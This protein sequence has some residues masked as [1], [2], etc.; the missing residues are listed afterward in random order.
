[1]AEITLT[2]ATLTRPWTAAVKDGSIPAGTLGRFGLQF[3]EVPVIIQAF[4]RMV[5]SLDFDVTEMAFTTYLCA[6]SFGKPFTALPVFLTRGFHHCAITRSAAAGPAAADAVPQALEGQRAGVSRGYTVTTGVWA[7]G[8]LA[9]QYGVDLDRVTWVPS[10]DD[11]VTEYQPP[12]NVIPAGPG[13]D[14]PA[15]V[16]SGEL[17][18]GVGFPSGP[19]VTPLLPNAEQAGYDALRDRGLYPINHLLVVKDELLARHPDLAPALFAA[20]AEAK[21]QYVTRLRAGAITDPDTTDRMLQRVMEI[22][23]A[24]PLP[25]GIAP[26]R[27]M[28]TA[29]VRHAVSQHILDK[30]FTAEELFPESTHDLTGLAP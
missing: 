27:A 30:P 16:A 8:I 24:D 12:P 22:T 26:N 1:M 5:R 11:H 4:R 3:E 14:V 10:G 28:V 6:R 9:D 13:Q 21:N 15:M 7:R 25:Y 23:G 20:Y 19:G 17:A 29:L 2:A 18:A